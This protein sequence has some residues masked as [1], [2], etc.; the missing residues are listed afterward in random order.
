LFLTALVS[1]QEGGDILSSSEQSATSAGTAARTTE[2]N[3]MAFFVDG[4]TASGGA[5]NVIVSAEEYW[6]QVS[7][8]DEEFMYDA[9]HMKLKE[10]AI[11][12]NLPKSLLNKIPHN[13]VKSARFSLVGRN[14]L[15]FY[16]NTPGT[17]PD[18]SAYS[19][20]FQAQAYD[21]SPVPSARTYGF[22]LNVGF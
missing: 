3:R 12:Y 21:F 7:K 6:R 4:V 8:V 22:S 9:S 10:F 13:P 20:S 19:T 14:L 18:A 15:Y 11:G 1:I 2:N 5:N 16:K 17:A